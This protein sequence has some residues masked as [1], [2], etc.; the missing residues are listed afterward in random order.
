MS[1]S[2]LE[3]IWLDGY[4]PTANLRSKTKIVEDFGGTLADCP[5]W[6]F[7][8]SSTQQAEGGS[9]DCLLK[10]VAI[11][12][13]PE[14]NNGFLVMTEVLNA[15]GTAHVSNGRATIDDDDNDFWFG[16]EQEY[17]LWDP[18]TNLPIGFPVTKLH[19]DSFTVRQVQ[20][21]HLVVKW[22]KST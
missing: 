3:Y 5:M 11:Y 2:K 18:E 10:P 21:M 14:R 13:D 15:D 6:S 17:F 4:T 19:K 8:G 12:P 22:W 9:S 16:F 1:K 20:R 7:D